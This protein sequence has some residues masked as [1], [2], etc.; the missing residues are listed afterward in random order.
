MYIVMEHCAGGTLADIMPNQRF[1]GSADPNE[2][3]K[4]HSGAFPSP[5]SKKHSS[6]LALPDARSSEIVLW[7]LL[8]Q[9]LTALLV[10]HNKKYSHHDIKPE[11]IFLFREITHEDFVN[12]NQCTDK[13]F[14]ERHRGKLWLKLG[15]FGQTQRDAGEAR[16]G[17]EGDLTD[18]M[19]GTWMYRPPEMI[20]GKSGSYPSDLFRVALL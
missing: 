14:P 8:H 12:I 3:W 17:A 4:C 5:P 19:G 11:N 1:K 20:E 10:L 6:F 7:H 15:D 13:G 18:I 16:A 2:K 9:M